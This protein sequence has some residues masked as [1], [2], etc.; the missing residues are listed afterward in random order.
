MALF[1]VVIRLESVQGKPSYREKIY[2]IGIF[3]IFTLHIIFN[4]FRKF[5]LPYIHFQYFIFHQIRSL[6]LSRSFFAYVFL[7]TRDEKMKIVSFDSKSI[8]EDTGKMN[9]DDIRRVSVFLIYIL[10]SFFGVGNI[11][12]YFY[13]FFGN[14]G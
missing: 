13:G 2:F 12:R 9:K 14:Q 3:A 5:I 10:T 4:I 6:F 11:A 8:F 7:E 1:S